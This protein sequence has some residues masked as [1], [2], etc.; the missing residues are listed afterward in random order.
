MTSVPRPGAARA[1]PSEAPRAVRVR[2]LRGSVR[3][4][5]APFLASRAMLL[6]LA[7]SGRMFP[8]RTDFV[9]R[10]YWFVPWHLLDVWGRWD[11]EWYVRIALQGYDRG[12]VSGMNKL[13]FYPLFPAIVSGVHALLPAPLRGEAAVLV[14]G[15]ALA[16]LAA[17]AALVLLH[18]HLRWRLDEAIA[19]R[20]IVALLAFPSAFVLSCMYTESLFLLLAVA[21]VHLSYRGRWW[22]AGVAAGLAT[23][24]RPTGV[25]LA[26]VLLLV[27]WERGEARGR[28]RAWAAIA[29]G[30]LAWVLYQA[31]AWTMTGDP[32]ATLRAQ[33]FWGRTLTWPWR[34]LFFHTG[35][36][37]ATDIDV[38]LVVGALALGAWAAL[39]PR[40]R[41]DGWFVLAVESSFLFTGVLFSASRFLIVAFPLFTLVAH[42]AR[43][44]RFERAYLAVM[45]PLQALYWIAW[46]RMY[47]VF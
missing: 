4:V 21:A 30:P 40:W 26:P 28:A 37:F 3:A 27:A 33:A 10:T 16:N 32:L 1:A 17:V 14:A 25:F 9:H 24:T 18:H 38:F 8:P 2:L 45:L 34:T 44:R 29:L 13:A 47:R 46:T 12:P 6:V 15:V 31:W 42:L 20:A 11:T 7:W 23:L 35:G 19:R 43:R 5:L 41:V 36:N 22:W 39:Q